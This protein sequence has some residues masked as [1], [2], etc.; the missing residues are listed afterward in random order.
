MLDYA[1][2]RLRFAN[3]TYK[4][5]IN[6]WCKPTQRESNLPSPLAGEGPGMRGRKKEM[7]Q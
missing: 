7:M 3:R 6:L 2:V 4:Y 5:P 1:I